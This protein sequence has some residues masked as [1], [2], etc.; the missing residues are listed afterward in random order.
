MSKMGEVYTEMCVDFERL[1]DTSMRWESATWMEQ[2]NEGRFIAGEIN[3]DHEYIYWFD[4]YTSL[5]TARELLKQ[6]GEDFSVLF[7]DNAGEWCM[8]STFKSLVWDR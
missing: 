2:V 1:N 5:M 8:T 4:N 7:D 3:W 6:F